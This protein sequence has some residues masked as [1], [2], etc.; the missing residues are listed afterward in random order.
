MQI[1]ARLEATFSPVL[2]SLYL[3][4]KSQ[5]HTQKLRIWKHTLAAML[6]DLSV[7]LQVHLSGPIYGLE[8]VLLQL[9]NRQS[10]VVHAAL[11]LSHLYSALEEVL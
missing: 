5:F 7:D 4:P 9:N 2:N 8:S 3:L 10:V 11:S 1:L 6:C